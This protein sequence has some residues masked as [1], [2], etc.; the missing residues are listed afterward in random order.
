MPSNNVL[1]NFQNDVKKC[2]AVK[3]IKQFFFLLYVYLFL[4]CMEL[5]CLTVHECGLFLNKYPSNRLEKIRT[6]TKD[7]SRDN[8]YKDQESNP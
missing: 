1:C 7:C 6:R 3:E 4:D 5:Y 8:L 2:D